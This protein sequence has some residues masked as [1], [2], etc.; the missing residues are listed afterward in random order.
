LGEKIHRQNVLD[1]LKDGWGGYIGKFQDLSPD[2][3]L[4]FLEKQGYRR[5]ADLLAHIVGW[6][7][8][9][10]QAIQMYQ[11]DPD[12]RQPVIDVDSFNARAVEKVSGQ[13]EEEVIRLFEATR[14][15]FVEVVTNLSEEEFQDA[16][17]INQINMELIGHLEDHKIS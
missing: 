10:L 8:T 3:R 14:C 1:V 15:R 11:T 7:E 5:L 12:A 9:G 4:V 13:T 6:W 16:R 17:I 2:A